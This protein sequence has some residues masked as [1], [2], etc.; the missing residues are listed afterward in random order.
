MTVLV[1][2]L[3]LDDWWTGPERV[4]ELPEL[5][6]S[7]GVELIL[8]GSFQ[9]GRFDPDELDVEVS[10]VHAPFAD[11]NPAS[12]SDHHR[13]YLLRVTRRV[14]ELTAELGARY[15]TVHPGHLTPVTIHDR[16]LAF[17]FAVETLG[18]VA[19]E[20]RSFGVEPLVE[21][22]PD[23]PI[24]LGTSADE[25]KGILRESGCGFT[26]DVGHALTAEGSLRPYLRLRPD[27]LHIHDNSG[28]SD[29]HLPPGMGVLDFDELRKALRLRALPVV[30]VRG[31]DKAH[32]AVGTV[33]EILER[34]KN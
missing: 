21:N 34:F 18:E 3:A 25:I 11:L 29:E 24:L 22:L 27:L 33:R 17:E 32:E 2:T 9:P 31:V 28:D 4:N 23:H 19:D 26:L 15:L 7:D 14:A 13:E 12:P 10:S 20:V 5:T 8:E 30:E 16:E 6:G 1:S